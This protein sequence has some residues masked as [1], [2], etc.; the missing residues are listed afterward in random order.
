MQQDRRCKGMMELLLLQLLLLMMEVAGR[1]AR[2]L[3]LLKVGR[4]G[5]TGRWSST[6][7]G[8]AVC[9]CRVRSRV[10]RKGA[11]GELP[12]REREHPCCCGLLCQVMV[13]LCIE[14]EVHLLLLCWIIC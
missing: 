6:P 10:R 5:N 1:E 11:G 8:A 12:G 3:L 2:L 7:P 4:G 14:G 13:G 9:P